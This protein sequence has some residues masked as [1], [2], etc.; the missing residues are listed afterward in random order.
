MIRPLEDHERLHP[1]NYVNRVKQA[2]GTPASSSR[3]FS[4]QIEEADRDGKHRQPPGRE[5][6]EDTYEP[7]DENSEPEP[8]KP[9]SPHKT[10]PS[11]DGTL[12][13]V[14]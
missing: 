13:I 7:G 14:V 9:A 1:S 2:E 6:G 5:F 8:T 11:D 3:D 10:T 12:D 4:Y